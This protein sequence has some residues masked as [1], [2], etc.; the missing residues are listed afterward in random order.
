M[1]FPTTQWTHLAMATLNGD[2]AGQEA[3][4]AMCESYRKPVEAFIAARGYR[5]AEVEDLVQDFFLRW[6]KSRAWKRAER[7]R[8]RFRSFLLGAVQHHLAHHREHESRQKRGGGDAR[9]SLEEMVEA[10]FEA[11]DFSDPAASE[12]DRRW[13][14][15]VVENALGRME[16]EFSDRGRKEEFSVLR[17]FLPG[18]AG[19]MTMEEAAERLG[20]SVNTLKASIHRLRM[21]FRSALTS[22]VA[23]TVS[24]P[25]EVA[26]EMNYLR[27][28]LSSE[29]RG[30]LPQG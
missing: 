3:L 9:L 20:Q 29:N 12:F 6:L 18:S 24:T 5:E 25:E 13:A 23:M 19:R 28:L 17:R 27:T 10:G 26:E 16:E 15:A 4:A 7:L 8:G 22:C 30:P 21:K 11:A 1:S 14:F 2:A